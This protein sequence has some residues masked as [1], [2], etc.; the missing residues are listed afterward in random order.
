[1]QHLTRH[2][3]Q[4]WQEDQTRWHWEVWAKLSF[5]C[6]PSASPPRLRLHC[7]GSRRP[8][9]RCSG[10]SGCLRASASSTTCVLP[11][12]KKNYNRN[13]IERPNRTVDGFLSLDFVIWA[14]L[15]A[16]F[17]NHGHE[18]IC[19]ETDKTIKE[20]DAR[21]ILQARNDRPHTKKKSNASTLFVQR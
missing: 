13:L 19:C 9:G 6:R 2:T 14:D 12:A 4:V 20:L 17:P 3:H 1:M 18:E 15:W 8:Q 7:A 5:A 10:P 21:A 16:S 11:M